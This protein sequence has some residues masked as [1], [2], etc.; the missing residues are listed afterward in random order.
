M[1]MTRPLAAFR[2][3]LPGAGPP[4]GTHPARPAWWPVWS[5]PA[6]MRAVRAVVVIP[7]VFAL[8]Y[9]GFGNLQ[10][11]LF[12]AFGGFASL[13]V[14]SFGG[15][16][17]DKLVA[18]FGLA[19]IGSL[20][21]IIGTAVSG[22][23]WLA[24]LVTIPVTFGIFFAGVAG[25]NAGAGVIAALFPFVL[26]VATAGSVS[27]IPDRLAGWWLASAV[28]TVA[29]LVFSPPSP[30]DR[31]AA[32][33]AGSARA[34]A[35]T[36]DAAV[37][38]TLTSAD[39]QACQAAKQQ[40]LS[41]FASTPFRPTGLATADQAMASVVQ[42]LEWSTVLVADATHGHPD[43]DRAAQVDRD[44]MAHTA[45]VLREVADLL[46]AG[47]D[48]IA[49]LPDVDELERLR[50]ASSAY[51]QAAPPDQD[52]D[53]VQAVARYAFHA[54]AIALAVRNIVA[55]ALIATRRADPETIAAR[56]RG[57]YGAQPEGTQAE[58]RVAAVTGAVG[59]LTRHASIR[60][61][62]FLNSLRASVALAAAV[63]VADVS[64]VQ[65]GFWVVLGT[66][67]VLRT[68]AAST[69]STALRALGGTVVGF[70][71]G[72]LLLLGIGTSTP[73]LWA[74]LPIAIAVAA[75]AP[76]TLPFAAGQAAFTIVIVVLFNLLAPVGWKV[77]LLRIQDVALGCLVSL[78]IGVLFWPRG[79]ASVVGDD[80]ADAF[81]IGAS[82]LTESVDWALGTRQIPPDAGPAAVTAGI[83]LDEA[84]RGF[85]AEQ[86]TKRLSKPDLWMLVMATMRLRLTAYS[87]AGLLGPARTP[88]HR[89]AAIAQAKKML[90]EATAELAAFYER[91]AVLVGRPAAH[92]VVPPIKVPEFTGLNGTVLSAD[93]SPE[94]VSAVVEVGAALGAAA[95]GEAS[96]ADGDVTGGLRADGDGAR[97]PGGAGPGAGERGAGEPGAHDLGMDGLGVD[98]SGADVSG[99]GGSGADGLDGADLVRIITLPHH[100][101]LLWVHEHLEHLISHARAIAEP[102]RHVAEQRRQPWWR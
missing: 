13:V 40:L 34:L 66:M 95:P 51:H 32:A 15:T 90:T 47:Q 89:H 94:E 37:R 25:P 70:V 6:A 20:G 56:R 71:I 11:A 67:S 53:E 93:P 26:P 5:V 9:E 41:A 45:V 75:Y 19:L 86:G 43:L 83:R 102:A 52:Y 18:H 57:W 50:E 92:D 69:E 98:G 99:A 27:T 96:G 77:G 63:L 79:A 33:A 23:H 1:S 87:L 72:A 76:G 85:L 73:A 22:I 8:T 48:G 16:K 84:L 58:R 2:A 82:Y 61:V 21:L 17:R 35:N 62:W 31:L 28:A 64:G 55:D 65:H 14:V 12:A 30:G 59:V 24:V 46:D 54:Q 80:L 42:S 39:N 91:V 29:V 97:E 38:G 60:S 10:M 88:M 44:L 74:A 7:S 36:L 100:P 81:R 68:N 4:G 3:S 101:H 78:V 49:V